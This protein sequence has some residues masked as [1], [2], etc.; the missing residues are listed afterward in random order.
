MLVPLKLPPG[1]FRPGTIYDAEGRWYDGSLVR[2]LDGGMQPWGGWTPLQDSTPADVDVGEVIRGMHAWRSAGG[3]PHLAFGTPTKLYIF[4]SGGLSDVTPADLDTGFA[5]ESEQSGGLYG[6]G[7]YGSGLYGTGDESQTWRREANTWQLGNFGQWLVAMSFADR[8][9]FVWKPGEAV[10]ALIS[11]A[12]TENRG[13]VVTPERFLV[14][15][16]AGGDGRLVRWASQE[17]LTDWTTTPTNTAGELSLDDQGEVQCGRPGNGETLIWTDTSLHRLRYIGG[18]LV[19]SL[20]RVADGCGVVSRQAAAVMGGQAFWMG[21]RAF[22]R[23]DGAGVTPLP[24]DVGDY[25]FGDIDLDQRSKIVARVQADT[26]EVIWHYPSAS[27]SGECD[28]Y[29][30][31]NAREGYWT[32]GELERTAGV[33]RGAFPLPL[34]ADASGVVYEHETGESYLDTDGSTEL[35]PYA[36]SGPVEIH[37]GNAVLDVMRLVPDEKTRGGVKLS[38]YTGDYPNDTEVL[39]GPFDVDQPVDTRFAGRA[40]RL[41]IDQ[42]TAGWRFGTPR[43]DVIP[44]GRR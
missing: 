34:A 42:E 2:W 6:L 30:A 8:R 3:T 31:L 29:V 41:R 44:G 5:D 23:Y 16:G 27:G 36:E 24:C 22:Y 11:G 43:L 4:A 19:Y 33:D 25:V 17:S 10:A 37:K 26:G 13:L 21:R 18:A 14:A 40:V 32:T 38:V 39:H 9:L 12:P 7:A 1:F 35:V 15:L 28:R 20:R